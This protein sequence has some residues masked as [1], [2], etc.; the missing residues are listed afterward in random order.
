MLLNP[1]YSTLR[2]SIWSTLCSTLYS[3]YALCYTLRYTIRY[4]LYST[5]L[6]G[7]CA[8]DY[9]GKYT[10]DVFSISI[11]GVVVCY[12]MLPTSKRDAAL[13]FLL[14]IWAPNSATTYRS[15]YELK[16]K[17]RENPW[18]NQC[19]LYTLRYCIKQ[20]QRLEVKSSGPNSHVLEHSKVCATLD[21][22][23]FLAS[24]APTRLDF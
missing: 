18:H 3:R 22:T 11:D 9:A 4:T 19:P 5:L 6:S 14:L 17:A 10:V 23:R 21:Q 12:R 15:R 1:L 13:N 8:M 7:H 24:F 2:S 16:R 20:K